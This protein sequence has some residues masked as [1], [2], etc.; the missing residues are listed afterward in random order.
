MFIFQFLSNKVNKSKN[1]NKGPFFLF[2]FLLRTPRVQPISQGQFFVSKSGNVVVTSASYFLILSNPN[3]IKANLQ[4]TEKKEKNPSR[5]Q[6]KNTEK[7]R[8]TKLQPESTNPKTFS[9]FP[10]SESNHKKLMN[11]MNIS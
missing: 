3:A 11:I 2:S 8:V 7:T 10:I 9:L 4:N 6:K 1:S 5:K